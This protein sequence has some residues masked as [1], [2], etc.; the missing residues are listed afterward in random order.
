[1]PRDRGR[2]RLRDRRRERSHSRE[3]S[4]DHSKDVAWDRSRDSVRDGRNRPR[5]KSR[6]SRWVLTTGML[7]GIWASNSSSSVFVLGYMCG[8]VCPP[9]AYFNY[10]SGRFLYKSR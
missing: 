6:D 10:V 8:T 4:R 9:M 7:V 2:E 5:A 1:M 3:R